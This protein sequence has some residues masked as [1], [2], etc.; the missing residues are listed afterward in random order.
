LKADIETAARGEGA[1]VNTWLV[2]AATTALSASA[3]AR[4][5][6]PWAGMERDTT[7]NH[8]VTGWINS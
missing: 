2:R 6:G 1:S 8:R 3:R 5:P 4:Q 7:H